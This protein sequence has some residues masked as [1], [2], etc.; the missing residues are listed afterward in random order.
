MP[1][2]TQQ[3]TAIIADAA[4]SEAEVSDIQSL[5]T[6]VQEL[7]QGVDWW[8]TTMIWALIF[9]ALAAVAV[10]LTTRVALV[11]AKQLG[12]AQGA[13]IRAKDAQLAVDLRTKDEKISDLGII[14]ATQQERAAT[15]ERSLLELQE[16]V[17]WRSVTA[18]ERNKFLAAAAH[19]KKGAVLIT[20]ASGDPESLAF[21]NELRTL[22]IEGKYS[23]PPVNIAVLLYAQFAVGLHLVIVSSKPLDISPSDPRQVS[24]PNDS[25]VVHGLPLG[26]ALDVAGFVIPKERISESHTKDEV[27]LLV[28]HKP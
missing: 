23:V 4:R 22:L 24:I 27:Q 1:I 12:D 11:R 17:K 28:G 18:D 10:V 16:K 25:P 15:A 20:T 9:A 5:T 8:N 7:S 14:L 2:M 19:I 21:A 6:R 13:L 26:I 3:Q